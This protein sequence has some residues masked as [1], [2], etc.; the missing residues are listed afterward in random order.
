MKLNKYKKRIIEFFLKQSTLESGIYEIE[1]KEFDR[2]LG[3]K[4][5]FSQ[6][7]DTLIA[8]GIIN[9]STKNGKQILRLFEKDHTIEIRKI[10]NF[11]IL[12]NLALQMQ[13]SNDKTKDL[14]SR[15]YEHADQNKSNGVYYFYTEMGDPDC[16]IVFA[17]LNPKKES[18][19]YRI[20]SIKDKNSRLYRMWIATVKAWKGNG[21]QSIRRG[22]AEKLDQDAFGNNRQPGFAAFKLFT[23]AGWL[24][25][26]HSDGTSIYYDVVDENAH[27]N[28][29]K[30]NQFTSSILRR[31]GINDT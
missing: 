26:P 20:G 16:W 2:Q 7:L 24:R 14:H 28:T 8:N 29:N 5:E 31:W 6:N 25:V 10:L 11:E 3:N 22:M 18:Y 23:H 1:Q 13:P 12:E 27:Q 15:F 21:K 30:I 4:P 19:R 9:R 17:R